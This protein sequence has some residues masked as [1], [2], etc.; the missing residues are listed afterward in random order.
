M[1]A[2]LFD[3]SKGYEIDELWQQPLDNN[4]LETLLALS[5]VIYHIQT[6]VGCTG[7]N[8]PEPASRRRKAI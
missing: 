5:G 6:N 4:N 7:H 2:K 8:G 3:V 1:V